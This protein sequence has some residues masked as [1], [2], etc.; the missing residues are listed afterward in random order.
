[1]QLKKTQGQENK[2]THNKTFRK[3]T[4]NKNAQNS[5]TQVHTHIYLHNVIDTETW[6][7]L[8]T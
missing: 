2:N 3:T 4:K 5:D 6:T 8:Q 7:L 1:M